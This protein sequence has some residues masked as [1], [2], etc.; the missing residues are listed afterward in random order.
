MAD[1]TEVPHST[2]VWLV[3]AIQTVM[4]LIGGTWKFG[5]TIEHER[6]EID[7]AIGT[8]END[9]HTRMT[10]IEN[11]ARQSLDSSMRLTQ[12]AMEAFKDRLHIHEVFVRDNFA[13]RDSFDKAVDEMKQS[14][15]AL[16]DR[17]ESRLDRLTNQN[18]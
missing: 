14:M 8:L 6:R 13:R 12:A 10:G 7:H 11:N 2:W 17:L 1:P 3:M 15:K 18:K 5:R 9:M 16:G 4:F